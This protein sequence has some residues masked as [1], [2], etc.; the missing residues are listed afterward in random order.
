MIDDR[1]RRQ[2]KGIPAGGQFD[3]NA[4]DEAGNRMFGIY[5]EGDP[6]IA[7]AR[8]L[9][10]ELDAMWV[11]HQRFRLANGA[12]TI[13]GGGAERTERE[14]AIRARLAELS[15]R[16]DGR[17]F[18]PYTFSTPKPEEFETFHGLSGEEDSDHEYGSNWEGVRFREVT[19]NRESIPAE[20]EADIEQG[21]ASGALSP[22]FDYE[23]EFKDSDW[24]TL[25]TLTV[26]MTKKDGVSQ[27]EYLNVL[28]AKTA[29]GRPEYSDRVRATVTK[30]RDRL[31]AYN[32]ASGDRFE[33]PKNFTIETKVTTDLLNLGDRHRP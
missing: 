13:R 5:G 11:E 27:D 31:G 6:Y 33:E 32:S 7:E 24:L 12:H 25:S 3:A 8:A 17:G 2:P 19:F 28:R 20:I 15:E 10:D 30:L 23:V 29:P 22:L 9:N 26:T 18:E 1:R 16:T 4:H 14:R 21:V